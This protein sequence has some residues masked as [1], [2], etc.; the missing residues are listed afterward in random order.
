MKI[1][2]NHLGPF[3]EVLEADT[4]L[5]KNCIEAGHAV[6]P[7]TS[8]LEWIYLIDRANGTPIVH[9]VRTGTFWRTSWRCL[10]GLAVLEGVIPAESMETPPRQS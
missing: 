7:E 9:N 4:Q 5:P 10:T 2:L 1:N 6:D 8:E 3:G